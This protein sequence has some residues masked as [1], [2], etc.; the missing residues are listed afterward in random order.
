VDYGDEGVMIEEASDSDFVEEQ[1]DIVACIV[2]KFLC[3]HK[4]LDTTQ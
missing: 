4:F 2:Q 1:G 3:N